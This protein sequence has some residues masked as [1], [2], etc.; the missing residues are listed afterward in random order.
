MNDCPDHSVILPEY[1]GLSEENLHGRN[2]YEGY[3]RGCG[4]KFNGLMQTI[5]SDPAYQAA[6]ALAHERSVVSHVRLMNIYLLIR[7]FLTRL[8]ARGHILEFG[9]FRGGSAMFMAKLAAKYLPGMQVYALDTFAGMPPTDKS[10]DGHNAG[11][12]AETSYDE[13]LSAKEKA[14][15]TNLH[16]VKGLF[17]QTTPNLLKEI[18]SVS[19]VHIDCDIYHPAIFA[20]EQVRP[21]MIP[22]GYIVFDD[23]TEASCLGATQAVEE[24][25]AHHGLRS[26]QIDPHFVF[27]YPPLG[28][29]Q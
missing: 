29:S 5:A 20:F 22:G 25:V 6:I 10:I 14:G 4:L 18:G 7:F 9:S 2:P 12:F 8:D 3:Q 28:D 21:A 19:L 13:V 27:R 16:L 11:D 23:A 15:L 1:P 17:D 26:E 24:I